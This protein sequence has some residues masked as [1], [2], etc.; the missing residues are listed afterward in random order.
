[1]RN[2]MSDP[3]AE[4][5]VCGGPIERDDDL[6]ILSAGWDDEFQAPCHRDCAP[7]DLPV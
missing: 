1:M 5:Y 3:R 6:V 4:C 2:V 7:R